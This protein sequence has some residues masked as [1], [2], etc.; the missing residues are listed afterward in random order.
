[1]IDFTAPLN[2]SLQA[3]YGQEIWQNSGGMFYVK[4]GYEFRKGNFFE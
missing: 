4:M 3:G 1:M 2:I